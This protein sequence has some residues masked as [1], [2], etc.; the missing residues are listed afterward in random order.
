MTDHIYICIYIQV[1]QFR[2]N[3]PTASKFSN[4]P[5]DRGV[6]SSPADADFLAWKNDVFSLHSLTMGFLGTLLYIQYDVYHFVYYETCI[7]KYVQH[8]HFRGIQNIP[9]IASV[10]TCQHHFLWNNAPNLLKVQFRG[11]HVDPY[12][13]E[14]NTGASLEGL[15]LRAYSTLANTKCRDDS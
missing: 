12:P 10:S 7:L 9:M 1:Q 6:L 15:S 8:I 11:Q 5:C 3:Q 2:S 14:M 13:H 4:N